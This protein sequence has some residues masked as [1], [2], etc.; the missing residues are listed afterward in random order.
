MRRVLSCLLLLL[1]ALP[2]CG[3][4]LP[5]ARDGKQPPWSIA[6]DSGWKELEKGLEFREETLEWKQREDGKTAALTLRFTAVRF[7][8]K[9]FGMR[10]QMNP[11]KDGKKLLDLA[12]AE[13]APVVS[14]GA[15]FGTKDEPVTLLISGG[16]ALTKLNKNLPRG[17]VFTLDA[18]GRATVAPVKDFNLPPEGLDF[19]VQNSPLLVA[20]GKV[21]YTE[22]KLE[23]RDYVAQAAR[24]RRT[25]LGVD[26]QGRAV[27]LA[28]DDGIWLAG[29]ADV[30][31]A[32]E[33]AGGFGLGSALNLDGGPSTGLAVEHEKG[34]ADVPAGRII[35]QVLVVSRREK[36]LP[37]DR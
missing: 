27:L 17:G 9:L 12:R 4:E 31:A 37:P 7:D 15:Y 25:G 16:R 22:T 33:T 1:A 3:G 14:N 18:R 35:P 30:L 23:H 11:V 5:A 32:P 10:V 8:T 13:K 21:V 24:H 19:A 2:G 36:P 26:S 20:D 34:R 28:C 6:K 29:F